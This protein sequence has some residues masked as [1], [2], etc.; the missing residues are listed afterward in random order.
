MS[1]ADDVRDYCGRTIVER[2]RARG[3]EEVVIRAGDIHKAMGFQNRLPLVCA[4]LGAG[5]FEKTY[6]VRRKSIDGPLNGSNTVFTFTI[7]CDSDRGSA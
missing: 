7:L 2:A 5:L 3:D 6:G 4:A 1:Y